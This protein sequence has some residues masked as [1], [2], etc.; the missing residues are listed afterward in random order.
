MVCVVHFGG[1]QINSF[2]KYTFFYTQVSWLPPQQVSCLCT[3]VMSCFEPNSS[4][5]WHKKAQQKLA[6]SQNTN[7][8]TLGC[9]RD[10]DEDVSW[11]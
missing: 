10:A 7:N 4:L 1:V 11:Q 9:L 5:M 2:D 3:K 8:N 6:N